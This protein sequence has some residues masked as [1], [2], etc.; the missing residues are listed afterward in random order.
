MSFADVCS[1]QIATEVFKE[2]SMKIKVKKTD[3]DQEYVLCKSL[4]EVEQAFRNWHDNGVITDDGGAGFDLMNEYQ[5]E[6]VKA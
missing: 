2:A 3:A 6:I 5:L 4:Q 1:I